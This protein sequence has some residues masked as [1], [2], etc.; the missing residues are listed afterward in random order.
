MNKESIEKEME[1]LGIREEDLIEKFILGAGKGG[2][3]V[4]KT[5]SCVYLKHIPTQ[6]EVKCQQERSRELNRL[7]ARRILCEKIAFKIH[8]EK[9]K[10]QQAEEKIKRQK[11]RRSRRLK[12]K[13][14]DEKKRHG[15]IKKLREKVEEDN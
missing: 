12:Q 13:I 8:Q 4:N 9:T 2:Q 6:I 3:K 15:A 5:S 10:K 11:K 7:L 1:R 14:L